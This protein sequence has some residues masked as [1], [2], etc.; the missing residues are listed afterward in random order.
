MPLGQHEQVRVRLRVDVAD[1]DEPVRARGRGRPRG[2]AGRRGS[3]H[4][5][6]HALFGDRGAADTDELADR[7]VDQPRRVV[8]A[9]AAAG[10][11]DEHDVVGAD[12][13]TPAREARLVGCSARRRAPRSRL[14]AGG[15]VSR[16]AVVV[17]G[18]G[19]YGKTC[20]FVIRASRTTSSVRR[21]AASSSP[22]KPTI[23]SVVRLKSR[24]RFEPAAE[25]LDAVAASHRAEHAVVAGLERHVQV[26]CDC[27][28]SRGARRRARRRR[29][30]P[31]WTRG[32]S[33]R[34]RG[35]PRARGSG[36][37]GDIQ[38]RGRGSS[39]G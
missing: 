38:Q 29:G 36:S 34:G 27:A 9:V 2:R 12:L 22:G 32:G 14:T 16:A 3:R 39:R 1:R 10:T 31:R 23:T 8:V 17:P 15:T 13:L 18:R 6:E 33:A 37:A 21:N 25:G 26:T 30:S 11:I 19:E 20:T 35:C 24:E 4:G 5:S 28:A 7:R